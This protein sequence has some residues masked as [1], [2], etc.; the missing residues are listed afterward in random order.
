MSFLDLMDICTNNFFTPEIQKKSENPFDLT[1]Q[2][3]IRLKSENIT[4]ESVRCCYCL[5]LIK[6]DQD[7]SPQ[8]INMLE[9]IREAKSLFESCSKYTKIIANMFD[10]IILNELMC[11][12]DEEQI[13][14]WMKEVKFISNFFLEDDKPVS[15]SASYNKFA[16]LIWTK[17]NELSL[18]ANGPN[19]IK[20][21]EYL[22]IGLD[23]DLDIIPIINMILSNAFEFI[24]E[25]NNLNGIESDYEKN[26]DEDYVIIEKI[27]DLRLS[28]QET[29]V[30]LLEIESKLQDIRPRQGIMLDINENIRY[31]ELK[32]ETE[33]IYKKDTKSSLILIRKGKYN[34]KNI[35]AKIYKKVEDIELNLA[36]ITEEIRIYKL[37]YEKAKIEYHLNCFLKYYG[38]CI[39]DNAIYLILEY[40]ENTLEAEIKKKRTTNEKYS[41]GILENMFRHL[42]KSFADMEALKIFHR[43]IKLQNLLIDEDCNIKIIDF[44][45]SI[46]YSENESTQAIE[47]NCKEGSKSFMAP[48]R[49]DRS[50]KT[51]NTGLADVF[52]LGIVFLQMSTL[53]NT[54]ELNEPK[55][56]DQLI[57]IVNKIEY[58]WAR[59]LVNGMLALEPNDRKSFRDSLSDLKNNPS[60]MSY[61]Q[62]RDH[63]Q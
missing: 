39:Y 6:L 32:L 4:P 41:E 21:L 16:E 50:I 10:S 31:E 17:A 34:G 36:K 38:T 11:A 28:N 18:Q 7:P 61:S 55:N 30:K 43:D 37:L 60:T 2:E 27:K 25:R 58:D 3:L 54:G 62:S 8:E 47:N 49:F 44:G 26:I 52:S 19:F 13:I 14:N 63:R 57:R 1:L 45:L 15:S 29:E 20:T 48:E 56:H 23:C 51:I 35:V 12:T 24:E 40:M 53:K 59:S 46:D 5:I 9:F 22:K 42:L 33:P